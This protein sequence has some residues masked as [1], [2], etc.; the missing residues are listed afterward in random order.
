MGAN[1]SPR[2]MRRLGAVA[3]IIILAAVA[4]FTVI[5]IRAPDK[6]EELG[7]FLGTV[8]IV[9]SGSGRVGLDR[10]SWALLSCDRASLEVRLAALPA[11]SLLSKGQIPAGKAAALGFDIPVNLQDYSQR[12]IEWQ[13]STGLFRLVAFPTSGDT[14]VLFLE[15]DT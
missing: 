11:D 5:A 14:P 8:E 12:W 6:R 2:F 9:R 15:Y 4:L 1:L 13:P 10:Y 3:G 7:S